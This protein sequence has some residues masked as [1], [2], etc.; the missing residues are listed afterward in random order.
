MGEAPL[1]APSS[2]GVSFKPDSAQK[3]ESEEEEDD[4]SEDGQEE[5]EEQDIFNPKETRHATSKITI[6]M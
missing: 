2:R 6:A 3:Q 5:Q 1:K 4:I